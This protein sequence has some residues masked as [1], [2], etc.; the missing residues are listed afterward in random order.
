MSDSPSF[1]RRFFRWTFRIVLVLVLLATVAVLFF[2]RGALYNRF[3]HL[4]KMAA[5][6][7]TLSE[8]QRPVT[9]DDGWNEYRCVLHTHSKFSH[10]SEMEFEDILVAAKE[11]HV[12]AMLMSDHCVNTKASFDWQ[13]RGIHDEVLFVPGFEMSDGFLVWGLPQ[14]M[15]LNCMMDSRQLGHQID[16][17]KGTLFYAHSE[18]NRLWDLPYFGGME[19]YNIHTD[20]KDESLSEM[21]P[22]MLLA[23]PDYG[24]HAYRLLFDRQS[25]ILKHWDELNQTRHITGF[26]ASDAHQNIGLRIE[27]TLDGK[28]HVRSTSPKPGEMFELN[29][30]TRGLL[31][32]MF[33]KLEPG[34][35]LYRKDAD[36]YARSL[37]FV[38]THV[39]AEEQTQESILAALRLG[40]AYVAFNF[41]A[42]AEGFVF[43]AENG[44]ERATM[45]E[46]IPFATGL[47]LRADAP[48]PCRYTIVRDGEQVYQGEGP[49]LRYEPTGPGKYRLEAEVMLMDEWTPWIY[50]NPI[51]IEP[52]VEMAAL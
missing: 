7:D 5:A 47:M 42:D 31:R 32:V 52:R 34:T 49:D 33:G 9:L 28:L 1:L 35:T 2:L 19:I 39:L 10:D 4:P 8:T 17:N 22:N 6:I 36:P 23:G 48:F 16:E 13:W 44:A 41:I 20:F 29:A 11:A 45:G 21:L 24:A 14:D 50:T 38:N 27:Y 40:R 46:S 12:D 26:A 18:E 25:D 51:T 30:L 15:T 3:V 37:N 43:F